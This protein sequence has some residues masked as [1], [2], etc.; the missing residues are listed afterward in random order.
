MR[1]GVCRIASESIYVPYLVPQHWSMC[2][3][4][5]FSVD[6]CAMP[7]ASACIYVPYYASW[8]IQVC[9]IPH[10]AVVCCD[11][12]LSFLLIRWGDKCIHTWG[13]HR[14]DRCIYIWGIYRED[15]YVHTW[16]I[17]RGAST[18]M[19][20]KSQ[21]MTD[22]PRYTEVFGRRINQNINQNINPIP[23]PHR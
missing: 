9:A 12:W 18:R 22:M 19:S 15:T 14:G 4:W 3:I 11:W 5:T 10:D 13:I 7:H 8:R 21:Y 2:H 6:L 17:R 23:R 1:N 16:G 20:H